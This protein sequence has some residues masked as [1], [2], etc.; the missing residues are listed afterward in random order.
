MSETTWEKL[1]GQLIEEAKVGEEV[2]VV[3][4]ITKKRGG[5]WGVV[6]HP[7]Y[8]PYKIEPKKGG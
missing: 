4:W 7:A 5:K 8:R 1:I 2:R 6:T 3:L